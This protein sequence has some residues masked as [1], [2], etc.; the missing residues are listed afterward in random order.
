MEDIIQIAVK[1]ANES[2]IRGKEITPCVLSQ[3]AQSTAG[4]S[5]NTS[6]LLRTLL[7]VHYEL[8]SFLSCIERS[9]H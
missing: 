8:C 1:K 2:G 4:R 6:I 5:L 9:L 3:V 7:M